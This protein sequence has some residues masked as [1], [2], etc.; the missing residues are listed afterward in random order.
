MKRKFNFFSTV[1]ILFT[2]IS[3]QPNEILTPKNDDSPTIDQAPLHSKLALTTT[4]GLSQIAEEDNLCHLKLQGTWLVSSILDAQGN[5]TTPNML[6]LYLP[7]SLRFTQEKIR[8]DWVDPTGFNLL[9][10]TPNTPHECYH[11]MY[12][13]NCQTRFLDIGQLYCST[14]VPPSARC[15]GPQYSRLKIVSLKSDEIILDSYAVGWDAQSYSPIP[16]EYVQR[17]V[18]QKQ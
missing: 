8:L 5:P 12:K 15:G 17:F 6:Y 9:D 4:D 18:F 1:A 11:A 13:V 2:L 16:V 3:C 7:D 10:Y 14:P